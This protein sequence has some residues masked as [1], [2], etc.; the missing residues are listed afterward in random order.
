MDELKANQEAIV[1]LYKELNEEQQEVINEQKNTLPTQE[2]RLDAL[3][4]T[5]Q[6]DTN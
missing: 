5:L 3:E 2:A 1:E 4:K 6:M